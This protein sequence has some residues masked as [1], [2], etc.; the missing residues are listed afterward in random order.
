MAIKSMI[1]GQSDA[2]STFLQQAQIFNPS[3]DTTR[4]GSSISTVGTAPIQNESSFG[5]EPIHIGLVDSLRQFIDKERNDMKAKLAAANEKIQDL[6]ITLKVQEVLVASLQKKLSFAT[7][8]LIAASQDS[9][10]FKSPLKKEP[11]FPRAEAQHTPQATV[12]A[13]VRSQYPTKSS[14][15]KSCT[16]EELKLN[17]RLSKSKS[18]LRGML[19][20][21]ALREEEMRNMITNLQE[22]QRKMLGMV[23]QSY[24]T[25]NGVC[26]SSAKGGKVSGANTN[27]SAGIG[28]AVDLEPSASKP[29]LKTSSSNHYENTD[30][31][32]NAD[33]DASPGEADMRISVIESISNSLSI[34]NRLSGMG[35]DFELEADTL[36]QTVSP[37]LGDH[38]PLDSNPIDADGNR[39]EF[40]DTLEIVNIAD[41]AFLQLNAET[42]E[43]ERICEDGNLVVPQGSMM[44][45][46]FQE[47]NAIQANG[48]SPIGVIDSSPI[49]PS[50]ANSRANNSVLRR[51]FEL[52]QFSPN[53]S[54]IFG[55]E[56]IY[57]EK[58]RYLAQTAPRFSQNTGSNSSAAIASPIPMNVSPAQQESEPHPFDENNSTASQQQLA[59]LTALKQQLDAAQ[60]RWSSFEDLCRDHFEKLFNEKSQTAELKEFTDLPNPLHE[61]VIRLKAQNLDQDRTLTFL[62][63]ELEIARSKDRSE[64][65]SIFQLLKSNLPFGATTNTAVDAIASSHT[66][67]SDGSGMTEEVSNLEETLS[68]LISQVAYIGETQREEFDARAL[69]LMQRIDAQDKTINDLLLI[70]K[71]QQ[72]ILM[73]TEEAMNYMKVENDVDRSGLRGQVYDANST[74][75]EVKLLYQKAEDEKKTYL[76]EVDRLKKLNGDAQSTLSNLIATNQTQASALEF[77][78]RE[79]L[80]LREQRSSLIADNDKNEENAE[81]MLL[82]SLYD[83]LVEWIPAQEAEAQELRHQVATSDNQSRSMDKLQQIQD[84]LGAVLQ[85][86]VEQQ[87]SALSSG[88]NVAK[89]VVKLTE[90]LQCSSNKL[91]TIESH[92]TVAQESAGTVEI[93]S[94]K[95]KIDELEEKVTSLTVRYN[96]AVELNKR[97]ETEVFTLQRDVNHLKDSLNESQR[98]IN[99]LSVQNKVF[100]EVVKAKKEV[101]LSSPR[102]PNYLFSVFKKIFFSF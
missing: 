102:Q 9:E 100:E 64:M 67:S 61:E 101:R 59:M 38:L 49:A 78:Q 13:D 56:D 82:R 29:V 77:A 25:E 94:D 86:F 68:N 44:D 27:V 23:I 91:S 73:S 84:T 21:H 41:D 93:L 1:E 70:N 48:P 3:S 76:E 55:L 7:G 69:D 88:D 4:Q 10:I 83:R 8:A 33:G 12:S 98:Y 96:S 32:D 17:I 90:A 14:T 51:L 72:S 18:K 26:G 16:A 74:L 34:A 5:T 6:T 54:V 66:Q 20:K 89:E 30:V 37:P 50:S 39:N 45:A 71:T 31:D 60:A 85:R 47:A 58:S 43:Y 46:V 80:T 2:L 81:S 99:D 28:G 75:R 11:N 52:T 22:A 19:E 24:G 92:L 40:G 15:K 42:L 87:S 65:E 62:R 57:I 35:K 53:S 36:M 79:L 95:K 63:Q 97:Y